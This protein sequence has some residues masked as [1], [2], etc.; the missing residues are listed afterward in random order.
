MKH[1]YILVFLKYNFSSKIIFQVFQKLLKSEIAIF[2]QGSK[3][4]N[5]INI[6]NKFVAVYWKQ[7]N[8][9]QILPF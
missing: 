8:K 4:E 5:E 2:N 1:F 7:I 3:K 6:Y 9:N